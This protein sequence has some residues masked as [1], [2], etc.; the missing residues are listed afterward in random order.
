MPAICFSADPK[1]LP[2]PEIGVLSPNRSCNRLQKRASLDF[3]LHWR[4]VELEV[5]VALRDRCESLE[6]P[7]RF[8]ELGELGF[9]HEDPIQGDGEGFLRSIAVMCISKDLRRA[10]CRASCRCHVCPR[11]SSV[12][13][14][15]DRNRIDGFVVLVVLVE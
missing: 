10:S 6:L 3:V 2:R 1:H 7:G 14:Q 8:L 11:K 9:A 13:R 4:R 15:M 5:G 12:N